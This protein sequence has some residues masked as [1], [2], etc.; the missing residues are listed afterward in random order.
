MP[1]LH[2]IFIVLVLVLL[3]LHLAQLVLGGANKPSKATRLPNIIFFLADDLGYGEV[4][5][6]NSSL[7][8]PMNI[9]TGVPV[10]RPL[11][12]NRT[13]RTPNLQRLAL[14]SKRMW[15]MY[16]PSAICAP[17]RCA[18]FAGRNVG[19][20]FFSASLSLFLRKDMVRN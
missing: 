2:P 3:P 9:T 1:S 7:G 12:P 20:T 4:N 5:Q 10:A 13:Y 19:R 6:D 15:R 14:Q 11:D 16:S 17:S 8:Y 18:I